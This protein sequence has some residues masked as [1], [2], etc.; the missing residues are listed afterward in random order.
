MLL[1]IMY[2]IFIVL[3]RLFAS[4]FFDVILVLLIG[5]EIFAAIYRKKLD[6]EK[7]KS[8]KFMK[9][10]ISIVLWIALIAA[11]VLVNIFAG[12]IRFM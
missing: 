9:R 6:D 10:I 8:F 12:P 2:L 11:G 7:K 3:T 1:V 5:F 4:P